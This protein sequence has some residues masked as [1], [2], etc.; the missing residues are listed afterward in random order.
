[1]KQYK[2]KFLVLMSLLVA[3]VLL[4]AAGAGCDTWIGKKSEVTPTPAETVT[5]VLT[6]TATVTPT[7][8]ETAT[9]VPTATATEDGRLTAFEEAVNAKNYKKAENMLADTVNYIVEASECCG[10]IPKA[11][12]MENFKGYTYDVDT[13]NFSQDQQAVK[14]LKVNIGKGFED[15]IIGIASNG[16]VMA[17]QVN[18]DG[19][20][21]YLY[22]AADL[23]LFDLE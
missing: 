12:A 6:P 15:D 23:S 20:V 14:K 17:Y 16:R 18:A 10:D 4:L 5:S 11:Q 8:I 3:G 19:K 2:G 21:G 7:P 1:M 22:V 9:P 13:F